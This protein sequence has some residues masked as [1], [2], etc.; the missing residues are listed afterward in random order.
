MNNLI[1]LLENNK[2]FNEFKF[3][4]ETL[5]YHGQTLNLED[6]DFA[7]FL[8]NNPNFIRDASILSAKSIFDI[9]KLHHEFLVQKKTETE[10]FQMTEKD[11]KALS[12]KYSILKQF[13]LITQEK[14]DKTKL[15]HIH[16]VD[17]N[18]E[19]H[20]LYNTTG[21]EL[22]A[23]YRALTIEKNRPINELELYNALKQNKTE[24]ALESL[25]E[26]IMK[27]NHTEEH[28]N[29]L[30]MLNDVNHQTGE[31]LDTPLGN[32]EYKIYISHHKV[33]T[34]NYNKDYEYVKQNLGEQDL[35]NPLEEN[36]ESEEK[37]EKE[38]KIPI[39]TFKEYS[40]LILKQANLTAEETKKVQVYE[41]FLFDI[42]TYKE[43]LTPEL[44]EIYILFEKL[45]QYIYVLE[46]SIKKIEDT[47]LRYEDMLNRAEKINLTNVQEKVMI[48]TRINNKI[49]K[50]G[51]LS[52]IFY[53]IIIL[54]LIGVILALYF[55]NK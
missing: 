19:N 7:Y 49:D 10:D 32:E 9:I 47:K 54:I 12:E 52:L 45:I 46:N 1:T 18:G 41:N 20:L 55:L 8:N 4:K 15:S 43:Y 26:A 31:T 17:Q 30:K 29:N 6:F 24:I 23:T 14:P 11:I 3:T 36:V 22:L 34:Y 33:V 38:E 27:N 37:V 44:Y 42:I 28:L 13:H 40:N 39:I 35:E 53:S 21:E 51:S 16:Y 25:N 2:E 48:L 5:T 50:A